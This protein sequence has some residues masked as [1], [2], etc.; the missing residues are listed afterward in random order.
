VPA[1]PSPLASP[2]P[3]AVDDPDAPREAAQD[4]TGGV[5]G[6]VL[7]GL[8]FVVIVVAALVYW[9]RRREQSNLSQKPPTL[10]HERSSFTKMAAGAYAA[11]RA[12][13]MASAAE[14]SGAL[15]VSVVLDETSVVA[16]PP[17]ATV[18]EGDDDS[19]L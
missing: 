6:G 16:P 7:G 2:A 10:R 4:S 3:T 11:E 18:D 14:S 12:V 5:V 9:Y 15:Q 17:R 8:A 19:K 13:D 1:T